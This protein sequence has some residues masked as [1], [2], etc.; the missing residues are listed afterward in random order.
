MAD[1]NETNT[2]YAES[3][4]ML[5]VGA[6][7]SSNCLVC[8]VIM[9]NNILLLV[10][11]ARTR[12]LWTPPNA[13]IA[14]LSV[15]DLL[16]GVVL[17]F[18]NFWLHPST[19]W[20][21]DDYKYAC[22]SVICLLY[23]SALQSQAS[24]VLVSLD[25]YLYIVHPF[26]YQRNVTSRVTAGIIGFTWL[27]SISI[28]FLPL[29]LNM[30]SSETGCNPLEMIS[31]TYLMICFNTFFFLSASLIV[32]MYGRI[33]CVGNRHRRQIEAVMLSTMPRRC[34]MLTKAEKFHWQVI[35][36]LMLVCGLFF[37]CWTPLA[38]TSVVYF[39][40]GL[41]KL[42]VSIMVSISAINSALNF[43]VLIV[44]DKNFKE[45]FMSTICCCSAR[46]SA[47]LCGGD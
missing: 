27:V 30:F 38:V 42:L 37:L 41:P 12:K 32:V 9:F 13:Y 7:I 24:L 11:L 44:M 18:R 20:I 17:V 47:D 33:L 35:K 46:Q 2:T 36:F 5:K 3:K 21:F 19:E 29:E 14:S 10:T 1:D 39:T 15:A 43:Y 28:G 34:H 26:W 4:G 45:A 25:R 31:K 23:V 6:V 8:A 40:A 16:V 22:L